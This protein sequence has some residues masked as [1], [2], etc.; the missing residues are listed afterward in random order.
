MKVLNRTARTAGMLYLIVI[1]T[2]I[3]S[4]I[5][6]PSQLNLTG[7]AGAV[8]RNIMSNQLLYL[9]GIMSWLVNQVFFL[10]L[11]FAFYRLFHAVNRDAAVLMV[12]F[13][14]VSVPISLIAISHRLDA[15]FLISSEPL[16]RAIDPEIRQAMMMQ[17]L[18]AYGNAIL[19]TQPFWGLWLLP[20]GYLIVKSGLVPKMLGLLLILGCA[21]YLVDTTGYL[22]YPGYGAT[23]LSEFLTMPGAAGEI[24]L[25]LWLLAK[26]VRHEA[27]V[28]A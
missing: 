16:M 4:L 21:G 8:A 25:C 22:L 3:F 2:G 18:D 24:G 7:D 23:H 28:S 13:V 19:V 17:S 10:L 12:A 1:A 14:L 5:Y 20:L 26:G 27:S 6:V 9:L 15:Y 11:P